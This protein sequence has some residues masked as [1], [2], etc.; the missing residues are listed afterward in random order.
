MTSFYARTPGGFMMEYGWGGRVV[1]PATWQ[2]VEMHSGPSLWGHERIGDR[3][4]C[5]RRHGG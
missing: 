2:A 1:D 4:R 5:G 3:P